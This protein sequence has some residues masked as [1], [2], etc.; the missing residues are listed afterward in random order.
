MNQELLED[1]TIGKHAYSF[2]MELRSKVSHSYVSVVMILCFTGF[3]TRSVLNCKIIK[4]Y[5]SWDIDYSIDVY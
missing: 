1:C 5:I 4:N 3:S 2:K